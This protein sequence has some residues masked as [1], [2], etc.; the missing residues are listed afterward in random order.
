MGA[1]GGS[2]KKQGRGVKKG[3]EKAPDRAVGR[4]LVFD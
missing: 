2:G 4:F 3:K 1:E